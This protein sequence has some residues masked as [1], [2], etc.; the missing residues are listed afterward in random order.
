MLIF[1]DMHSQYQPMYLH[2]IID[3]DGIGLMLKG[4]RIANNSYVDVDDIGEGDDNALLCTTS[5]TNC[6]NQT[7]RRGD[8]YFLGSTDMEVGTLGNLQASDK[9]YRNRGSGVVRLNRRGR[10]SKRGRFRCEVPDANDKTQMVFVNIGM[11]SLLT[12]NFHNL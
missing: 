3:I 5:N 10:T 11:F 6:C 8:W 7:N 1:A 9:F 12:K 2:S 4:T